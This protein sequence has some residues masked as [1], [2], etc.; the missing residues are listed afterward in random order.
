[1]LLALVRTTVASLIVAAVEVSVIIGNV[2]P[3]C[4]ALALNFSQ[5]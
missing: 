3:A 2:K 1:M 4:F 5:L